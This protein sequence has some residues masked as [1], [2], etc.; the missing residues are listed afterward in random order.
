MAYG[1]NFRKRSYA[2]S[3]Y[4]RRGQKRLKRTRRPRRFRKK[5][6]Q[7]SVSNAGRFATNGY[8]SRMQKRRYRRV[9]HDASL[10]GQ[11]YRSL[12]S[13]GLVTTVSPLNI[14]QG[15]VNV[16]QMI[17]DQFWTVAGGLRTADS[18][19]IPTFNNADLTIRGGKSTITFTN[20]GD[21][22]TL[23]TIR[24]KSWRAR[25]TSNGNFNDLVN[26]SVSAAWD[27]SHI[28]DTA[29][30]R[31]FQKHFKF[32]DYQEHL[33]EPNDCVTRSHYFKIHKIDQDMFQQD[34]FID[35]WIYMVSNP[36]NAT[37]AQVNVTT[38]HNLSFTGD[39]GV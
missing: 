21:P 20:P 5:N 8:R 17:A 11:H 36:E 19:A 23:H 28:T 35:F 1:P 26:T 14:S 25:T 31:D 4:A 9:L 2:P 16:L 13:S 29:L 3:P 30:N 38:S 27:P 39:S 24:V 33:I 34:S 22:A 15:T 10:V 7:V 18:T 6:N 12:L 32:Y 37:A